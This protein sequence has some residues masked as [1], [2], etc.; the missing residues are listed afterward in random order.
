[1]TTANTL[2]AKPDYSGDI[3]WEACRKAYSR[4]QL[5]YP[6]GLGMKKV[7]QVKRSILG[8]LPIWQVPIERLETLIDRLRIEYKKESDKRGRE[9]VPTDH[10]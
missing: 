5:D 10:N 6:E 3:R 2:K 8:W 4:A 9:V 1:L 7:L